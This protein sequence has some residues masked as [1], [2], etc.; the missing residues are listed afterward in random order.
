[1]EVNRRGFMGGMAALFG[2]AYLPAVDPL[3]SKI[4]TLTE[5]QR[6]F[7]G[8]HSYKATAFLEPMWYKISQ[9]QITSKNSEPDLKLHFDCILY[10]ENSKGLQVEHKLEF[11]CK[12]KKWVTVTPQRTRPKNYKPQRP[13]S[14]GYGMDGVFMP[15]YYESQDLEFWKH[16][17]KE[18]ANIQDLSFS[19]VVDIVVRFSDQSDPNFFKGEPRDHL[20]VL[21]LDN[22][23]LKSVAV[24][25][26]PKNVTRKG[27]V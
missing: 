17:T 23:T 14:G 22:C 5:A 18:C 26:Y 8:V 21:K 4:V 1:M 24:K 13:R 15:P 3:A 20:N 27:K 25:P 10:S 19:S 9:P 12:E 7:W 6:G 2:A 16:G 11:E